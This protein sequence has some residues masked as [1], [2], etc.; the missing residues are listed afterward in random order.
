MNTNVVSLST[1]TRSSGSMMNAN[2]RATVLFRFGIFACPLP[3]VNNPRRYADRGHRR[4]LASKAIWPKSG[5]DESGV[6]GFRALVIV[7][8]AFRSNRYQYRTRTQAS[9]HAGERF[10]AAG[11]DYGERLG[12]HAA[13]HVVNADRR[14]HFHRGRG[15][16]L[17]CGGES[18]PA[19]SRQPIRSRRTDQPARTDDRPKLRR[20]QLARLL[21]PEIHPR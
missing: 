13:N 6:R 19:P 2:L 20:A 14:S 16:A 10:A 5:C 21:D 7:E 1:S 12:R 11:A 15:M 8:I 18:E 17:L 4:G 9:N 3:I